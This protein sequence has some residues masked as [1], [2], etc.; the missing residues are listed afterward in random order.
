MKPRKTT[1]PLR[2]ALGGACGRMGR[3][4]AGAVLDGGGFVVAAPLEAAGHPSV[5]KDYGTAIGLGALETAV[6]SDLAV[7]VDAF[8]DFSAPAGTARWVGLCAARRIPLV[9]GTTGLD[10]RGRKAVAAAARVVPVVQAPNM[11]VGISAL[12][13]VLPGLVRLLGDRYDIEIVEAHHRHKVDAPSGTA[14]A[15]AEALAATAGWDLAKDAVYGRRGRTGVRPA[16]QIGLHAVRGGDIVGEHRVLFA[17]PGES[18]E[19]VHRAHSRETFALGALRA[20]RFAAGAK[21]GL[22]TMIDVLR[23]TGSKTTA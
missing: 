19:V 11:S 14:L 17:G 3:Q 10:A 15:L 5:G 16:R 12:L 23:G 13:Q 9:L 20:A 18:I 1:A 8:L 2:I 7:P 21:A 4:I 6:A 22:Y